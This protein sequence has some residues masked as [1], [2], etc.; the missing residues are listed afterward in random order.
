M[1]VAS[2]TTAGTSRSRAADTASQPI[3][4]SSAHCPSSITSRSGA[5]RRQIREQP[6]DPCTTACATSPAGCGATPCPSTPSAAAPGL[7]RRTV[8]LGVRQVTDERRQQA[9]RNAE[10]ERPLELRRPGPHDPHAFS[11]LRRRRQQRR[12]A[13]PRRALEHQHPAP[14]PARAGDRALSG[15]EQPGSLYEVHRAH[16]EARRLERHALRSNAPAAPWFRCAGSGR[17][18][19]RT[20]RCARR[21]RAA[22]PATIDRRGPGD[23]EHRKVQGR[24]PMRRPAQ[25]WDAAQRSRQSERP[26]GHGGFTCTPRFTGLRRCVGAG[27]AFERG[28]AAVQRRAPAPAPWR[29][30][31]GRSPWRRSPCRRRRWAPPR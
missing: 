18:A 31:S 7:R 1:R 12:L 21:R 5:R 27:C 23:G 8:A 17:V 9:A 25:A 28:P 29:G 26:T 13:D 11:L 16:T 2:S 15:V 3:E 4:A 24:T 19:K 22:R 10:R 14:A 6:P 20:V 30:R